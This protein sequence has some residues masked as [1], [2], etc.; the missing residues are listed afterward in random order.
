MCCLCTLK[1]LIFNPDRWRTPTN[2]QGRS[3]A[4]SGAVGFLDGDF[5]ERWLAQP[6]EEAHALLRGSNEA[7]RVSIEQGKMR[8]LLEKVQSLH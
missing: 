7:E 5:L 3:D 2:K 6:E 4:D 1:I 8:D